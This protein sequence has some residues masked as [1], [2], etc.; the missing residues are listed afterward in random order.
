MIQELVYIVIPVHNRM[1]YTRECIAS[2][3]D[4]IP[5]DQIIIVDDGSTD[6]TKEML[7]TRFPHVIVLSGDGNLFWTAAINMGIRHALKLGAE[8]VMT[9]NND[10]IASED[11]L[12]QMMYWARQHPNSL[13]GA[14]DVDAKSKKPYYG[15]EVINWALAKSRYLLDELKENE[16]HGLHEVSLFPARGLLIPKKVFDTVGLFEE[17]LLPHYIADYDF[18][19][20]ARRNGFPVYCNYDAKLYTYPEEGGDKKISKN[21]TLRNYYKHL[22]DIKGGGNLKNFTIYTFRNCPP[23]LVPLSLSIGYARRL[24]GFWKPKSRN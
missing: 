17:K 22:F 4:Q 7:A 18:T 15:G 13:L 2:L 11:F 9:L 8:Y 21:K 3:K 6:G 10:T 12:S 24:L 23:L 16:M 19:H 20:L 14:L 5:E 1:E